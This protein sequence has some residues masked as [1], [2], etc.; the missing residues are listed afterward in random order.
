MKDERQGEW[1]K[2][3]GASESKLVLITVSFSISVSPGS[4]ELTLAKNSKKSEKTPNLKCICQHGDRERLRV[5][6]ST[7][8][9]QGYFPQIVFFFFFV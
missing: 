9:V 3:A 2:P 5:S 4:S 7:L 1:H 6:A 8:H